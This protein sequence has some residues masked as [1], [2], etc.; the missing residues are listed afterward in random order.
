MAQDL[1][2]A[3]TLESLSLKEV[4]LFCPITPA[5]PNADGKELDRHA[6]QWA[7][8]Q[9]LCAPDSLITRARLGE[10]IATGMP[11]FTP[12]AAVSLSCYTYWAFV[13]DD[14]LDSLVDDP[15]AAIA[16][17]A[18]A[19]RVM[20]EPAAAPLLDNTFV[21][22]L[23]EVRTMMDGCLD[24]DAMHTVRAE[25]MQWLGGQLWKLAL[26]RRPTPPTVGEWL[27]MRW[28]KA[29]TGALAALVPPGGGYA[30][31]PRD[32]DDPLV[33]AFTQAVFYP[34]TM[35]NELGSLMKEQA[36]GQGHVNLLSAM[37]VEHGIGLAEALIK[38]WE[39]YERTVAVM[40][41][42]QER[43]LRDARSSVV[44]YATELPQWLPATVTWMSGNIRYLTAPDRNSRQEPALALC[45]PP[46]LSLTGSPQL[47]DPDDL[48]PPPYP[49]IAWLWNQ[50]D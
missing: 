19:N 4:K 16:L 12:E 22:S 31:P 20:T 50:L 13:W 38:V 25:H 30:L 3:Q 27:R 49:D 43:L 18:E 45:P 17:T 2:L 46:E 41:R 6:A 14:H 29:G 33:R 32:V 7:V 35:V 8:Q 36:D 10:L 24:P 34:C 42:L 28:Q 40:L 48:T 9:G 26:H 23:R 21:T 37:A 5:P 39:L 47:W 44:R 15:A 11:F 1:T